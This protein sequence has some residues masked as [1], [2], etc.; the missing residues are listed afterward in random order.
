MLPSGLRGSSS[1]K[2]YVQK[3][4]ERVGLDVRPSLPAVKL[5]AAQAQL[6]E[7]AKAL[8]LDSKVLI[9]DEPT[10]ALPPNDVERLLT[11][12]EDL[13]SEDHAIL[14]ISHHL[15]E[16][17]RIA[18]DVTVLRDGK[19]VGH[20]ACED[21]STEDMIHLMVDR[22]VSLYANMLPKPGTETLLEVKNVSSMAVRDLDFTL[23]KGE[24][25]GFAGL[26]GS[27]MH[28][29][30]MVLAGAQKSTGGKI[31]L[32][33]KTLKLRSPADAA[34]N[35]IDLVPEERKVQGILP[36][37]S[38][39]E[40][41]HIGRHRRFTRNG[42]L[43]PAA[44]KS[45]AEDLVRRFR[46]R[47][48]SLDQRIASLSGGNQQ[49]VVVARC[50]QSEPK[51]LILAEPTRG[52]DV[53]AKDDIHQL[54]LDLAANGTSVIVVSSEM[55]EVLALS[56]KVAVFSA[57]SMTG[58]LSG[59]EATPKKVMTLATPKREETANVDERAA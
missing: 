19:L 41:F 15:A 57:G 49:K 20:Y 7:I 29:A 43:S 39:Q 23:N 18:D 13:R 46:V 28:D 30:A 47:L 3:I 26:I 50:V 42:I 40:N 32:D 8:A 45:K 38:V 54:I 34:A 9:F 52:V 17:K 44:M 33:G 14:Y 27:G 21:L 56:H 1:E 10:S 58:L 36:G 2:A 5:S 48:A 53:G 31:R 6:L 24:I 25:I 59:E 12:I 55:D 37:Q 4:L 16:V 22:P 11:L 51:V 35:G